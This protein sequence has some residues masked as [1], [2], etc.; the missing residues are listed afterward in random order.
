MTEIKPRYAN[1][2]SAGNILTILFGVITAT[3]MYFT[4]NAQAATNARDI[5]EIKQDLKEAESQIRDLETEQARSDER[6]SS[7]LGLL[8]KIDTRLARI[9]GKQ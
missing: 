1:W 8:E 4:L 6:F 3:G 2:I 7:I 5:L 9:E